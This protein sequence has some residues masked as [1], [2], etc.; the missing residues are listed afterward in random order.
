MMPTIKRLLYKHLSLE[1][2]LRVL[3]AGFFAGFRL[4]LRGEA[5]DYPRFLQ[6]VVR[7][8]DIVLDLGANLGYYS[9]I[10]SRLVGPDGRVY[11][12]EPVV[13]VRR[14]LEHNLRRCKN[15][16][17][18]PFAL[19]TDNRKILMLND[20]VR[21]GYMGTGRNYIANESVDGALEFEVEMRRGSEIFADLARID[22]IKCDIEGYE[23]IVIPE[24]E[25]LII[26][27]LPIV[28]LETG[29]AN[30]RVMIELFRR[31]GYAAYVLHDG[32]LISAMHAPELDIF[33]VPGNQLKSL[34]CA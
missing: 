18:V 5:Y 22:F 15:V 26:K 8:G 24:L 1:R 2:Y 31:W 20:S 9:R 6:H 16:E 32:R 21:Q 33:F 25:P 30:R 14:V 19:G 13:P 29:G 23:N 10:L 17:I 4:G 12:V 34:I 7:Q 3:S 28:L 27:H 11:A